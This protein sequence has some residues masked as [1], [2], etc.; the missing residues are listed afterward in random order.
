MRCMDTVAIVN[1]NKINLDSEI[2]IHNNMTPEFRTCIRAV[3]MLKHT[4][5]K[6]DKTQNFLKK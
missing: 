4:E 6:Y 5:K 2:D 1:G 3:G